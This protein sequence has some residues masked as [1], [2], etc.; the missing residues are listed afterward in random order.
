MR[1]LYEDFKKTYGKEYQIGF[2]LCKGTVFNKEYIVILAAE[3]KKVVDAV[4]AE[5]SGMEWTHGTASEYIGMDIAKYKKEQEEKKK[6]QTL[7]QKENRRYHRR[8]K[9]SSPHSQE[10]L[11]WHAA[12]RKSL[13]ALFMRIVSKADRWK[14]IWNREKERVILVGVALGDS[15]E[16]EES[17]E[18]LKE[19]AET[20]GAEVAGSIIQARE[21]IHSGTYVGKGKIEEYRDLLFE[22]EAD[23]HRLR[24]WLSPAQLANLSQ[25]VDIKV[26]DRTLVILDI[27]AKRAQTKRGKRSRWNWPSSVTGLQSLPAKESVFPDWEAESAQGGRERKSWRWTGG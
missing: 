17:L 8:K 6:R 1:K 21:Q 23:G 10:S 14:N 4:T 7:Y 13:P 25:I 9:H 2:G 27:F 22:T 5:G 18:E 3:E 11:S 16:A 12:Q 15:Q 24:R 19:L 26:M 20:A